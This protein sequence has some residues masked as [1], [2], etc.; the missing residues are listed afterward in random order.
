[1]VS[2]RRD[3]QR[4]LDMGLALDIAEVRVVCPNGMPE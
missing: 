1:M 4:P 2:G 3:F